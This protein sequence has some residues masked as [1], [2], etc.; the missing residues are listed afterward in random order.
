MVAQPERLSPKE[1]LDRRIAENLA[2]AERWRSEHGDP[3]EA[4]GRFLVERF[5]IE[6]LEA[7]Y[8]DYVRHED[9]FLFDDYDDED[10]EGEDEDGRE[11]R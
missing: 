1:H 7:T 9:S 8:Q 10:A 6:A 2:E 11:P 5:G 3:T 4:L